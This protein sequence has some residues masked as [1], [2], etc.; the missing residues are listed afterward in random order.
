MSFITKQVQYD[1]KAAQCD[2]CLEIQDADP[3]TTHGTPSGWAEIGER[4]V[5]KKCASERLNQ[6]VTDAVAAKG[7]GK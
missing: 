1:I 3:N 6:A 4:H 5:C 2:L 7:G